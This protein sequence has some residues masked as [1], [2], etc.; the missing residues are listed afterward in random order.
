[1]E[2]KIREMAKQECK[3]PDSKENAFFFFFFQ[4]YLI[5]LFQGKT[6]IGMEWENQ[7]E[8]SE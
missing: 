4:F 5:M 7:R 8:A 1:M 3:C 6:N 2:I